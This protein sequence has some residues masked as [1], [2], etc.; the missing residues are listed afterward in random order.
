MLLFV[1]FFVLFG[2]LF[3]V[4]SPFVERF[5][6]RFWLWRTSSLPW[7]LVPFLDEAAERLLLR[8]VG[9]SYIFMHRLLFEYFDTLDES[10]SIENISSKGKREKE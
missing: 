4:L 6:V 2:V 10:A 3:V 9:S 5:V 8:K 1:L 7:N